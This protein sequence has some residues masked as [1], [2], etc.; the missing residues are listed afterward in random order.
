LT[1]YRGVNPAT[2]PSSRRDWDVG[3]ALPELFHEGKIALEV[4]TAEARRMA[5]EI[6]FVSARCRV[7]C[8][9][10]RPREST[11]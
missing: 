5:S 9:L 7:Q 4:L 2:G 1:A 6:A 10:S 3:V 11:P 8:P